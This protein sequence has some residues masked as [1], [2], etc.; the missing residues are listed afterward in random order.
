MSETGLPLVL[1]V[2]DDEAMRR[3][4]AFLFASVGLETQSF[5]SADELLPALAPESC[6]RPGA[7]VLDVRMPGM[8]GLELQRR[9]ASQSFPLP[10]L[11][12]TGHGDVAMAVEALK[13][14]AFDFI[15]KPFKE[16]NLL[17]VV[18]AA[19]RQSQDNL[20]R[21]ARRRTI[22]E[23]LARLGRREREVLDGILAGKSNKIIAYELDLSIKTIEAYRASVMT[24]MEAASLP[25]LA[26][27]VGSVDGG[28][29]GPHLG[30]TQ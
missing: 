16:Q 17:D 28:G 30:Q 7:L 2:D 24:K 1:I 9:L 13:A 8:S 11:I 29:T 12:V 21:N 23:R 27:M 22:Q 4:M 10:I 5:A 15:E 14:G 25:E 19:I 18:T 26:L 20:A 6:M 3:S